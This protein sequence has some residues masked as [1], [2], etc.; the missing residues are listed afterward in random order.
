MDH[1]K[2]DE[3]KERRHK[4]DPW[5]GQPDLNF[6]D[7]E[8][9]DHYKILLH[10]AVTI[11][12]KADRAQDLVQDTLVLAL[13]GRATFKEG[14]NLRAWLFQI[15]RNKWLSEKRRFWR[16]TFI[17]DLPLNA[18]ESIFNTSVTLPNAEHRLELTEAREVIRRLPSEQREAFILFTLGWHTKEL[19]EIQQVA[20]GTVKSRVS[21]A[22]SFIQREMGEE[23]NAPC[24]AYTN[25]K[26][27]K[28][29]GHNH[30]HR[31][32]TI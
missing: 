11:T 14:S 30:N 6:K 24:N 17:G 10:T 23:I 4:S 2:P 8:L 18:Q 32:T 19:A 9:K 5:I 16:T 21:R 1:K 7:A 25:I 31:L 13:R 27:S 3:P 28:G 22:R 20:E 26:K 12:G 29:Y 15:M